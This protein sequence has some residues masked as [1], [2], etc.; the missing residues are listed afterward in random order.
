MRLLTELN[1]ARWVNVTWFM[2][3]LRPF[4]ESLSEQERQVIVDNLIHRTRIDHHDEKVLQLIA[5]KHPGIVWT[6][7]RNRMDRDKTTASGDRYEAV[8]YHMTELSKAL[9]RDARLAVDVARSWYSPDD[10]L[11]SYSGGRLLHNVFPQFTEEFEAELIRLVRSGAAGD[12]DFVLSVLGSY[13]GGAFL[14]SVCKELIDALPEDDKR[15]GQV[16][17]ILQ[18]TGGVSGQFGMVQAYQGK[19]QEMEDWLTDARPKVRNFAEKY[20]RSLDRGIAAEQRRSESDYELRRR[21]WPEEEEP[22]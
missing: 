18:S 17:I 20:R 22:E 11:F 12:I 9:A 4:I 19:K 8:P 21:E 16:E 2:P 3:P 13:Q 7:F 6:F 1:D 10:H 14:H 5:Q 15:I